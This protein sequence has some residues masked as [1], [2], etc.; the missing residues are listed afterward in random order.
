MR[1]LLGW[2]QTREPDSSP[3]R[4]PYPFTYSDSSFS[5]YPFMSHLFTER[6]SMMAEG[7]SA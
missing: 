4:H 3:M 7:N 2:V 5:E 6:Q 1:H